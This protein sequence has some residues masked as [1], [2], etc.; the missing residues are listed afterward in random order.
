MTMNPDVIVIGAG[1]NGLVAATALAKSGRRVLVL[2]SASIAGGTW[3]PVE[4]APGLSVPLEMEPDWIP[5]AVASLVGI[6]DKDF[7]ATTPT[8]VRLEDGGLLTL[9]ANP[10]EA[11]AAIHRHS[12]RDAAN[13]TGF[14]STL[15]QLSAFLETL[16]QQPAPDIDARSVADLTSLLSLGRSFRALGRTN[17]SELLRVLPM[18]VQDLADDFLTFD[19]LKA[20]VAAAGVR[21]IRQGPRSGG[22]SFTLLHYLAGARDAVIRGRRPLRG[23]PGAFIRAASRAA[24]AA[25][26]QIRTRVHVERIN[27]DDDVVTGVTLDS[28]E[29]LPARSVLSTADPSTT[30]LGMVDPAWLD[31][32]FTRS[33]R[34]IRYRGCAA[35]V[36]YSLDQLP[37]LPPGVIALSATTD[38]IERPFDVA[39]YGGASPRPH[40]EISL[41]PELKVLLARV[42]YIPYVLRDGPWDTP[43]KDALGDL[44]TAKI[45]K[46]IPGFAKMARVRSVL[47]PP[48]LEHLFGVREGALTHGEMGLDQI[49]FMRPVAG[50]GRHAMPIPGLYLGGAGTHPGPGIA[51][52]PGYLA[53]RRVMADWKQRK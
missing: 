42:Q 23:G 3:A 47:T 21:D 52:G 51:G 53:A 33:V 9:S 44:V 5:P 12:P 7:G 1:A 45:S 32:E 29:T 6:T 43:Q 40:V 18:P 36:V 50:Y 48:D 22:T 30:L 41:L 10:V 8:S 15:R 2:E 4:I 38:G 24:E 20:A 14:M 11:A 34:N 37:D 39:K 27:V 19:P 49:L 26:V 46:L 28:G 17:M 31:P 13:W 35:W 25:R 16:Y